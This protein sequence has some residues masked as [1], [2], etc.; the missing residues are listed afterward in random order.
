M[1]ERTIKRSGARAKRAVRRKRVSERMREWLITKIP[2]L[3]GSE[4]WCILPIVRPK[5]VSGAAMTTHSETHAHTHTHK[6]AAEL[7]E[8]AEPQRRGI[9][10]H[11]HTLTHMYTHAH[12]R[13]T[14]INEEAE[15][16]AS[17]AVNLALFSLVN[18]LF[19]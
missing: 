4:S 13:T 1:S 14:G 8:L 15:P 16:D 3:R 19:T 12:K 5:Q 18:D 6:R 9:A 2:I 10:T 11:T 17:A 7:N